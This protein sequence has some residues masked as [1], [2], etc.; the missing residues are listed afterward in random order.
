MFEA[1]DRADHYSHIDYK[2]SLHPQYHN[3]LNE[4][5][6]CLLSIYVLEDCYETLHPL[7][8]LSCSELF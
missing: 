4:A 1:L 7:P 8:L 6:E 5:I 3:S 2:R